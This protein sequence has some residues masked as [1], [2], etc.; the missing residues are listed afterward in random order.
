VFSRDELA[1]LP[2]GGKLVAITDKIFT[3][4]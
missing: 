1:G 3:R 4:G 2:L